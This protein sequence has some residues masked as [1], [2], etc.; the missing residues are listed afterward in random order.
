MRQEVHAEQ[1]T[2]HAVKQ[3][4]ADVRE[5]SLPCSGEPGQ[6]MRR[7]LHMCICVYTK[8]QQHMTP[9]SSCTG[10]KVSHNA[11]MFAITQQGLFGD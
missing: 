10:A 5:R 2:D 9:K 3:E 7:I 8:Y 6:R 11:G 1:G 4:D